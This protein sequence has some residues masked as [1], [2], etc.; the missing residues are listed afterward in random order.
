MVAPTKFRKLAAGGV[1]Q[2]DATLNRFGMVPVI[3]KSDGVSAVSTNPTIAVV[4]DDGADVLEIML[5]VDDP[6]V[7]SAA[8]VKFGTS[9][10]NA[11]FGQMSVSGV[12]RYSL[13]F[14]NYAALTGNV[15]VPGS[16]FAV[17]AGT[18]ITA[19]VS[20]SSVGG[21]DLTTPPSFVA[22]TTFLQ[23]K[24]TDF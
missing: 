21:G 17:T 18:Q 16:A 10:N 6:A 3:Q 13:P 8:T 22:Y 11:L 4:P 1:N 7:P 9:A 5:L 23:N 12:G 14:I 15:T 19:F 20:A 24:T 2:G